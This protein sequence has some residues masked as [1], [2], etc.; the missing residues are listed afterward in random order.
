MQSAAVRMSP[1]T[2]GCSCAPTVDCIK[3]TPYA[4][5]EAYYI[6]DLQAT[7]AN[8][9]NPA[10]RLKWLACHNTALPMNSHQVRVPLLVVAIDL[11]LFFFIICLVVVL[12]LI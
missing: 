6:Q 3:T 10:A 2:G 5:V 11:F 12:Q 1:I 8:V 7:V 9:A 4:E